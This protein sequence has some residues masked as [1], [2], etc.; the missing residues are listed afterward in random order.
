MKISLPVL[1]PFFTFV[2]T[3]VH[4]H[5]LSGS[6]LKDNMDITLTE[7]ISYVNKEPSIWKIDGRN[8]YT[9]N[10]AY[11]DVALGI[12]GQCELIDNNLN[13]DFS[14]YSLGYYAIR[15]PGAFEKEKNHARILIDQLRFT[16]AL[17]DTTR[18][19]GGKLR[20]SKGAFFLKS[21]A[22]LLTN[23][24]SGFKAT[25]IYGPAME[26]AYSESFWGATLSKEYQEYNFLLTV[27]PRFSSIDKY[28][29]S[30]GNWSAAQRSN[31]EERYL[32]SYNDY[33]LAKRL[34]WLVFFHPHSILRRINKALSLRLVGSIRQIALAYSV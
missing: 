31:S 12:K 24:Y 27:A 29:E 1:I 28:Y 15:S 18:L 19:E 10:N 22:T 8:P 25:R 30:S 2:S 6:E 23:Y 3:W 21:P 4:G 26:S 16:Y 32:L 13:M 9:T 14:F 7:Q 33:R 17:S 34:Y 5:C 11:N 20:P